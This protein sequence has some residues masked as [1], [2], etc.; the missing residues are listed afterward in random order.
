MTSHPR[1]TIAGI[2]GGG[3]KT[4]LSLAVIAA[5]RAQ[6][7]LTVTPFKKG[8]DYIDAG[9]LAAAARRPCYNLDP[10]L[11]SREKVLDSFLDHFQGD[12]AVIEGNRGLFD[13]MDAEGS[14]STAE[15][16]KLLKSPVLLIIDCTKMTR[17][18]AAVVLGCMA[19]DREVTINGVV[20]NRIAGSRHEAVIRA[21]IE[22]YCGLPVLGALPK[23]PAG[24]LPERHMGLTPLQEH[25]DTEGALRLAEEIAR[26]YLDIESIARV[27]AEAA[28]LGPA[29][30]AGQAAAPTAPVEVRIGVIRDAAFQFYYPENLEVLQRAGA[31]IVAINAL[32]DAC[33]PEIDALYIG[34]GFPETNAIALAKNEGFRDSVRAMAEGGLPIYAE[35]GGLMFLGESLL[36][37][38]V[39]YPMV[40][41]FPLSFEMCAKPQAHGYTVAE[42]D[43]ENPFYPAGTVLHGHEFHYSAVVEGQGR[44]ATVLAMRR[45]QG[46]GNKRDGMVYKNVFA[47]YSHVHALGAPQWTE[48]LIGQAKAFRKAQGRPEPLSVDKRKGTA[49][50]E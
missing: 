10:F 13:G 46:I 33:L 23:L 20:L 22:K 48:G 40:G 4:T 21:S 41:I 19:L 26:N 14:Y 18:A 45:G 31:E 35:C 50:H 8:P 43:R 12:I 39:R 27:A 34:G 24:D 37:E 30:R 38:G 44:G 29:R 28:P 1:L 49:C 47:A 6:K 25:P 36:V 2:R 15:L 3:G 17:T 7:G 32:A 42:A 16:A 11:I 9:W 5:L